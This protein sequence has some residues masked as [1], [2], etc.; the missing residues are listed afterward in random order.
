VGIAS[1][2]PDFDGA[3][4]QFLVGLFQTEL[5]PA[6]E[7]EWE[8]RFRNP[9][10]PDELA[11]G[12]ESTAPAFDLD[13]AEHPFM[14][15]P[16][17]QDRDPR[18]LAR[19]LI[20]A[21]G[22]NTR[23]QNRDHFIKAEADPTVCRPCAA[24]TLFTMQINAP[25]GGRGYLT[26]L[27]GG[28]PATTL[29]VGS[30]LWRTIWLNVLP[31]GR[32]EQE[33]GWNGECEPSHVYPWLDGL[34][35]KKVTTTPQDLHPL[36]VF[37]S[38]SRRIYLDFEDTE[39]GRCDL[40]GRSS[41]HLVHQYRTHW[42]GLDYEGAWVHPLTPYNLH[43][44]DPP[45]SVKARRGLNTYRHWLGLVL[46]DENENRQPAL[47]VQHYLTNRARFLGTRHRRLWGFGYDMDRMKAR[48]WQEG[49][50]PVFAVDQDHL[51]ALEKN[52]RRLV[53]GADYLADQTYRAVRDALL[54]EPENANRKDA[55][56][57]SVEEDFWTGTESDF[58]DTLEGVVDRVNDPESVDALLQGWFE[59]LR[60]ASLGLFDRHARGG[61]FGSQRPRQIVE[62]RQTLVGQIHGNKVRKLL[63]LPEEDVKTSRQQADANPL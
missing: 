13:H 37:W 61:R 30:T 3:L 25:S 21:P 55:L 10:S 31:A 20:E 60:D 62:A 39:T 6:H 36:H 38:T 43:D 7:D 27:R 16:T 52:A 59:C 57:R 28:G 8:R 22:Q 56:L 34:P 1:P 23:D 63:D 14:Q 33:H 49:T 15:D 26:S 41:D 9:P 35:S 48:G 50:M 46:N 58:Y 45:W 11:D 17:I 32:I 47:V 42:K 19:L 2:R 29:L 51:S 54:A 5:A 18:I 24:A 40:C 12:L 44:N 53:E 4:L